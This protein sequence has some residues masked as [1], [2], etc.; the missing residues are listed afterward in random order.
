MEKKIYDLANKVDQLK[1]SQNNKAIEVLTDI[2]VNLCSKYFTIFDNND[3]PIRVLEIGQISDYIN[4]QITE[5]R[6]KK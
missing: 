4:N 1:Q 2:L 6:G 3:E 5:L